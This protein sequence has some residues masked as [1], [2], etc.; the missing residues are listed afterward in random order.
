KI[1]SRL[2]GRHH[3]AK[4]ALGSYADFERVGFQVAILGDAR[5]CGHLARFVV[6]VLDF[7]DAAGFGDGPACGLVPRQGAGGIVK[8]SSTGRPAAPALRRRYGAIFDQCSTL[9]LAPPKL[10]RPTFGYA[11]PA[12]SFQLVG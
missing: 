6:D 3:L 11:W 2:C 8:V 5:R 4:P 1:A 9:P 7:I 12:V 10:A